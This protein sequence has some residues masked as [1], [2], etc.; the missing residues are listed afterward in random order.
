MSNYERLS[1]SIGEV[2]EI[3]YEID[4]SDPGNRVE[5][6]ILH[7]ASPHAAWKVKRFE[8]KREAKKVAKE[9]LELYRKS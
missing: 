3:K 5:Y 1:I 4:F 9:M 2:K 8:N 6:L 7:K